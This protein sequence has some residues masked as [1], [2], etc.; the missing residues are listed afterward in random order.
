MVEKN[1]KF[2]LI[3]LIAPP[4]SGKGTLSELL[5]DRKSFHVFSAGKMFRTMITQKKEN[6]ENNLQ[7]VNKGDYLADEIVNKYAIEELE[8]ILEKAKEYHQ[9]EIYIAL[10]GYPRTMG[11]A[12]ELEGWSKNKELI[13]VKLEGLNDL[14]IQKRLSNRYL[15]EAHEHIFNELN[16][17][18]PKD[19]ICPKD[20]SKLIKRVDD[21]QLEVMQ[22]RLKLHEALTSP[23]CEYF[24]KKNITT[25]TIDSSLSIE[26]MY[27]SFCEKIRI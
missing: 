15:C 23:I 10:D 11:Q 26:E 7:E 6:K 22:R 19:G 3:V 2:K 18:F 24:E 1:K 27:L 20:G 5:K 8:K 25:I 17:N 13:I 12:K 14:Q 21:S 9:E 4:G 16:E